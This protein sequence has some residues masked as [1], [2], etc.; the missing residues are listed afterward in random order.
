MDRTT[1]EFYMLS[2]AYQ[3]SQSVHRASADIY[4]QYQHS[5]IN[6]FQLF[7]LFFSINFFLPAIFTIIFIIHQHGCNPSKAS[8][9]YI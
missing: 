1:V 7:L 6:E 4:I 8:H 9:Y 5:P 3:L 2:C